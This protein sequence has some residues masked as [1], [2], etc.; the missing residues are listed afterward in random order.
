ML[1]YN[2]VNSLTG[3]RGR[4]EM[5][6]SDSSASK[7]SLS[8][9]PGLLRLSLSISLANP[10]SIYHVFIPAFDGALPWKVWQG[11]LLILNHHPNEPSVS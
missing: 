3:W 10:Q 6:L 11:F 5:Q 9:S 2:I 7:S 8:I 1:H 4:N